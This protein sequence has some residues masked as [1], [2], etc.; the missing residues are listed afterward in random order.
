MLSRVWG[1]AD[2]TLKSSPKIEVLIDVVP[3]GAENIQTE[4]G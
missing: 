3:E 4:K 1:D 2:F